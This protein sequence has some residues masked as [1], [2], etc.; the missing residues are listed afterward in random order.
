MHRRPSIART[1]VPRGYASCASAASPR[2]ACLP[3]AWSGDTSLRDRH[4]TVYVTAPD[5]VVS[6]GGTFTPPRG[7]SRLRSLRLSASP[8]SLFSRS[9]TTSLMPKALETTERAA[10]DAHAQHARQEPPQRR[11]GFG[12]PGGNSTDF[13]CGACSSLA[14][15]R[16]M[17]ARCWPLVAQRLLVDPR[18]ALVA[19]CHP[20]GPCK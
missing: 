19:C 11:C 12:A 6:P 17:C 16:G 8:P 4:V 15:S 3:R 5:K 10:H 7:G 20:P 1:A 18:A 9:K 14:L 13:S 2:I